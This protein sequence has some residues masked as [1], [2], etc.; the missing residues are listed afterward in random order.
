MA[1]MGKTLPHS[2]GDPP[3]DQPA[4]DKPPR[5]D[6]AWDKSGSHGKGPQYSTEQMET[7]ATQ[8]T[9]SILKQLGNLTSATGSGKAGAGEP[10]SS[11]SGGGGGGGGE[12]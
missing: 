9:Q 1:D 6:T 8:V 12:H 4:D 11:G 5:D 7:L 3:R 10:S 2:D